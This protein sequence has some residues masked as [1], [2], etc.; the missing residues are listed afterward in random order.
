[1]LQLAALLLLIAIGAAAVGIN[2]ALSLSERALG[3][4][5]AK[6]IGPG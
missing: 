4:L 2:I 5:A 1:M 3:E 6:N